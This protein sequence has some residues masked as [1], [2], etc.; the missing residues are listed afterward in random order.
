MD[1]KG[2]EWTGFIWLHIGTSGRLVEHNI[3]PSSS[4]K[5]WEFLE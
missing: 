4:I 1:I 5:F 3:E 2:I